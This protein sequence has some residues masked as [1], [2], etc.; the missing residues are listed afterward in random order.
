MELKPKDLVVVDS[1]SSTEEQAIIY[2]EG[3]NYVAVLALE[4]GHRFVVAKDR[5]TKIEV[6]KPN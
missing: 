6:V 1:G 4:D 2:M 5:L 3:P